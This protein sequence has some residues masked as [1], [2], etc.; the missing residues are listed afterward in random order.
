MVV[1]VIGV[2]GAGK[3][4]VGR[5]VAERLG[6]EFYDADDFHPE[7]NK[8]KMH[9]GIALTDDDRWPW[10]SA[11]RT[12]VERCLAENR[13]AVVACSALKQSYRDAIVGNAARVKLVYLKGSYE[14]MAQRL[15]RR[16]GHFFD[17][18]LLRSQ[19]DTLEE[20][21]DA[22]TVDASMTPDRAAQAICAGL[23]I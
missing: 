22:L 11:I 13:P 2:A 12:L 5:I 16:K 15:A 19:F 6:W 20:P 10:L 14:L 18:H 3:T 7:V 4:T 17:P 9:R 1:I 23:D 8:Q 21:S